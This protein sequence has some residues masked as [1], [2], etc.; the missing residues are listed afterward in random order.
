MLRWWLL[1]WII[2]YLRLRLWLSKLLLLLRWLLLRWWLLQR[3]G[4]RHWT[5]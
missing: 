2:H 1:M 5:R 4:D 3:L